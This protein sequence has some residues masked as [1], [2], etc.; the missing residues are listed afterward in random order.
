MLSAVTF[1]LLSFFGDGRRKCE[2]LCTPVRVPRYII[3][4]AVISTV[5][6]VQQRFT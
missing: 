2:L 6:V 4:Q 5:T 3:V 1:D